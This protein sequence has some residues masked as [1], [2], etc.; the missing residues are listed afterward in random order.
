[1]FV[2]IFVLVVLKQLPTKFRTISR[3]MQRS[4][5]LGFSKSF[6]K[7][8]VNLVSLFWV[9]SISSLEKARR[10]CKIEN[11]LVDECKCIHDKHVDTNITIPLFR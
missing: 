11:T 7:V 3:V 9:S 2:T 10:R 5:Y 8:Y 4:D 6:K 1:M